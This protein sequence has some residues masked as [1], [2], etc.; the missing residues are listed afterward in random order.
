MRRRTAIRS[1]WSARPTRSTRRSTTS[2]ISISSAISRRSRASRAAASHAGRSIV[3]S[4]DGS[5]VHRLRQ[6]QSGQGQH[7]LARHRHHQPCRR[8]V[9]QDDDWRRHGSCAFRGNSPALTALL[10]GQ[11]EVS[12]ASLPSSI[13]FIRSGKL[14]GLAVTST[15]RVEAL[16]DIPAVVEFGPRLRGERVV[17]RRCTKGHA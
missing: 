6:G 1:F 14:R 11:V 17:R 2:S 10:G 9:V 15:T 7:V 12:I 16:P 8:R 4:Q 5:R 13:E 3:S